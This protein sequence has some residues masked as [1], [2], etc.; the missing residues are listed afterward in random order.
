MCLSIPAKIEKIDG[1]TALCSVGGS[2]LQAH[3]ELISDEQLKPG[4][5][6]LVH[7]GFAIQKLDEQEALLT[8]QTFK[9][10]YELTENPEIEI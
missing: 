10:Y 5:Y 6:V 1:E 3:L 9:E 4:D 8:L 2:T 7:T